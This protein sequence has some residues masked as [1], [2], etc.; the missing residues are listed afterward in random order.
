[1]ASALPLLA[2]RSYLPP[3][4][5]VGAPYEDQV[6]LVVG[7]C[8][9]G[10][11][12]ETECYDDW[13]ATM[14]ARMFEH[15]TAN[16]LVFLSVGKGVLELRAILMLLAARAE[17]NMAAIHTIILVDPYVPEDEAAKV[18]IEFDK[19]LLDVKTFYYTGDGAYDTA[20]EKLRDASEM[21]V[22]AVGALNFG[23]IMSSHKRERNNLNTMVA[24]VEVA[25][26]RLHPEK[27]YV[28]QAFENAQGQYVIR[29]EPADD[30]I[31]RFAD[32]VNRMTDWYIDEFHRRPG[33]S[34]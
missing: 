28:V 9:P 33:L 31:Q 2:L 34:A 14:M 4:A 29:D 17:M 21:V 23:Y 5:A 19:R 12:K 10:T 26:K 20:L 13:I 15:P 25:K 8:K 1:M 18:Q 24:M 16:T 3:A 32:V 22:G 30:F 27:L 11:P 7:G 6:E